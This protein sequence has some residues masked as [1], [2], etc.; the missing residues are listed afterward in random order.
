MFFLI[1]FLATSY[2]E[3]H[4]YFSSLSQVIAKQFDYIYH[5]INKRYGKHE[6]KRLISKRKYKR[7]ERGIG[8]V[9]RSFKLDKKQISYGFDLL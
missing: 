9:G 1:C 6:I 3:N 2:P 5:E 4:Y 8:A 7:R